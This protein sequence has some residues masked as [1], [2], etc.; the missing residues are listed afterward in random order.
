MES[1]SGVHWNFFL[2]VVISTSRL[3]VGRQG[4]DWS[5]TVKEFLA[6]RA[7]R[8]HSSGDLTSGI[9]K[10]GRAARSSRLGIRTGSGGRVPVRSA[11]FRFIGRRWPAPTRA[12]T[13]TNLKRVSIAKWR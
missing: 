1:E 9:D 4:P 8:A 6:R 12:T 7:N 2:S 3:Y 5:P 13:E 10:S 11:T